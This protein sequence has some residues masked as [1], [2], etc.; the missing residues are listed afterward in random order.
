MLIL[1]QKYS[2]TSTDHIELEKIS[3]IIYQLLRE[4]PDY[5]SINVEIRIEEL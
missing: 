4:Q 5:R 3:R 2:I 1:V